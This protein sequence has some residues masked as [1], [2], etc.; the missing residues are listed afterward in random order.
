MYLKIPI[1]VGVC[2]GLVIFVNETINLLI[3]F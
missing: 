1:F 2:G 3:R